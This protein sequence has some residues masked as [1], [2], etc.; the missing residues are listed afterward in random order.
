M[1]KIIKKFE[2]NILSKKKRYKI[3]KND[4]IVLIKIELVSKS[5]HENL[6]NASLL[7]Y[8]YI[9]GLNFNCISCC[10]IVKNHLCL[11]IKR[12]LKHL[13]ETCLSSF[14]FS[15]I[16]HNILYRTNK[17]TTMLNFNYLMDE[18]RKKNRR[19]FFDQ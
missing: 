11:C 8:K 5:N 18:I 15:K 1:K 7:I 6:V 14:L 13:H 4:L 10:F 12:T 3:L 2:E 9:K 19:K 17:M 16:K